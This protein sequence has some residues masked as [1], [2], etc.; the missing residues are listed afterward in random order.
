MKEIEYIGCVPTG[1]ILIQREKRLEKGII[2]TRNIKG[3]YLIVNK[4]NCKF[5]IGSS[6]SIIK[7]WNS[8]VR[9][10]CKNKHAN[11]HLQNAWNKYGS[12]NFC[13][14]MLKH[15]DNKISSE[16]LIKEEQ[17][18]LD[19]HFGQNYC[20]NHNK[21]AIM[22]NEDVRCK[23]SQKLRG[24]KLSIETIEKIRN[25]LKGRKWSSNEKNKNSYKVKVKNIKTG[26]TKEFYSLKEADRQFGTTNTF[27]SIASKNNTHRSFKN[28]WVILE[29]NGKPFYKP[30]KLERR[31][32]IYHFR[33]VFTDEEKSYYSVRQAQK[34]LGC[35]LYDL[36]NGKIYQTKNGWIVN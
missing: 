26:E 22:D 11:K 7:R 13:F 16:T 32:I 24:R 9:N 3:I 10:L 12:N 31:G 19:E 4:R 6:L 25:K 33:N 34:E 17:H 14:C 20:Y 27:K 2:E 30:T 8:H 23:I 28:E 5:Y 35:W 18:Q 15:F 21:K 1:D 36:V 29:L